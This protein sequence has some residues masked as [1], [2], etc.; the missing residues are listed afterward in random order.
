M[1]ESEGLVWAR[2]AE[3]MKT[4]GEQK[5]SLRK[6]QMVKKYRKKNN[7]AELQILIDKWR[8]V[9]QQSL[10]SL[11]SKMSAEPQ[12]GIGQLIQS[13]NLDAELLHYD[14]DEEGF[15]DE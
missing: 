13:W 10:E 4:I 11:Q 5:E 6:L 3:L 8:D 15:V 2:R 14:I 7:L 9:C 12:P 1:T